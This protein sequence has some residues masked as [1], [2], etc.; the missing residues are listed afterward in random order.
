MF[1]VQ[2]KGDYIVFIRQQCHVAFLVG[3]LLAPTVCVLR[4]QGP[5]VVL[6]PVPSSHILGTIRIA[7]CFGVQSKPCSL[8][9]LA[10]LP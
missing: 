2:M 6:V 5:R 1:R 4:F 9:R 10:I 8:C 7:T 3:A